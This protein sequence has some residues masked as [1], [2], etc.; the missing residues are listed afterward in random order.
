MI[1][2]PA[3][4]SPLWRALWWL[5]LVLRPF[6]GTLRVDGRAH[7]PLE[8]GFVLAS[9][10]SP[11]ADYVILGYTCPRQI[12]YMAKAEAFRVHPW[13]NRL[14]DALGTFP[15]ERGGK[16]MAA[17]SASVDLLQSGRVVG[18]FPEGTRSRDGK[19]QRGK[20]GAVRI[21]MQAQLPVVPVVVIGGAQI[22]S[23]FR[24]RLGRPHVIVR[25]G[26]PI[27]L[28]GDVNDKAVVRDNTDVMMR[29][30]ADLL[31]PELRGPYG[32]APQ[33]DQLAP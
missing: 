19:L 9:N 14:L 30:M 23:R 4:A 25:F 6:F 22:F 28:E 29:G 24:L 13:L 2:A 11:G 27:Y 16:D 3:D 17:F 31:P 26:P 32:E 10:H 18:M 33:A 21:A 12:Y 5:A 7:V 15:V 8:G 20:P 1:G